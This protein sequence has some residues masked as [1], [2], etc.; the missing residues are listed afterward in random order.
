M[1]TSF[2]FNFA[3]MGFRESLKMEN[4]VNLRKCSNKRVR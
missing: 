2:Y 4:F 3:K 1:E